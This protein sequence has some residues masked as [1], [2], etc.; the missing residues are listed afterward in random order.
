MFT[1]HKKSVLSF[2]RRVFRG[3]FCVYAKTPV[4]EPIALRKR[5]R[6][7]IKRIV[8]DS[9]GSFLFGQK[10]TALIFKTFSF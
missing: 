7:S 5:I 2:H 6:T 9:F 10:R 1:L 3:G 4:G 8:C